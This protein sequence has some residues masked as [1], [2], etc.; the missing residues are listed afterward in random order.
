LQGT[1]SYDRRVG[2]EGVVRILLNRDDTGLITTH[3]LALTELVRIFPEQMTNMHFQEKL[4][5]GKLSFDYKLRRGV[6]TTSNGVELMKSIGL[7]V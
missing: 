1:N 4:Q 2:A 6:V 3:D 7:E 5:E